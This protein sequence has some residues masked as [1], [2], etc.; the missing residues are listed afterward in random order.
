MKTKRVVHSQTKKLAKS[1]LRFWL[2]TKKKTNETRQL[3]PLKKVITKV[4][5]ANPNLFLSANQSP[6]DH[7]Q[8]PPNKNI[9]Q[10]CIKPNIKKYH[11]RS[12]STAFKSL[13]H[14]QKSLASKV[15]L[16]DPSDFKGQSLLLRK[17]NQAS[18]TKPFYIG[19]LDLSFF[20][21]CDKK[22]VCGYT[23]YSYE[24]PKSKKLKLVYQNTRLC[25]LTIPY[26]AGYL[27][28]REAEPMIETVQIQI[29]SKP[30][31]KPDILLVDG[32]GILHPEKFG[33]ACHVGVGL[34]TP[35][36]GVAKTMFYFGQLLNNQHEIKQSCASMTKCGQSKPI[37]V[38]NQQLGLILQTSNQFHG[39]PLIVSQG[40][41]IGLYTAIKVVLESMNSD[42]ENRHLPEPLLQAD[43]VSRLTVAEIDPVANRKWKNF[44]NSHL[45]L[46][47]QE[48]QDW[49]TKL[50]KRK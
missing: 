29:K 18:V 11:L 34:D 44:V 22:A 50:S 21:N 17:F 14:G 49:I 12:S 19:G 41:K 31:I 38:E 10:S 40:H 42:F 1:D 23:I 35:T 16:K 28:F 32:N 33:L 5:I 36:V 43:L 47:N 9:R 39:Q 2:Q 20:T 45:E 46:S 24:G 15:E 26:K 37:F 4:S 30:Q 13:K 8:L 6:Q 25:Q 27:G 48:K 3:K 7:H